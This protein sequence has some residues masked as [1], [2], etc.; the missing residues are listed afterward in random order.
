M[1][2]SPL[3]TGI[4]CVSVS[5]HVVRGLH[6][7]EGINT[8]HTFCRAEVRSEKRVGLGAELSRQALA[9]LE[10]LTSSTMTGKLMTGRRGFTVYHLGVE[11]RGVRGARPTQDP[12]VP[13][14]A[15]R[16]RIHVIAGAQDGGG[17]MW[18][19]LDY[20]DPSQQSS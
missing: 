8:L 20:N 10:T 16:L 13:R 11:E 1:P 14:P 5:V 12:I 9:G 4:R 2:R 7:V 18:R 17:R 3:V 15:G 19:G 6:V